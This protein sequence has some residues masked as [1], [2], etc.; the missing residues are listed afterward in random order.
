MCGLE[1]MITSSQ[2]HHLKFRNPDPSATETPDGRWCQRQR[3]IDVCV[4]Y[5]FGAVQ[6]DCVECL[7]SSLIFNSVLES[8]PLTI[9][10]LVY[11]IST[12]DF[13]WV[14][15][16]FCGNTW[17]FSPNLS[18][19]SSLSVSFQSFR[20]IRQSGAGVRCDFHKAE[21]ARELTLMSL[22]CVGFCRTLQLLEFL[23]L[24]GLCHLA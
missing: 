14:S 4:A 18:A 11:K 10:F 5:A 24:S 12:F 7:K 1:D 13:T 21:T 23:A 9:V 17:C 20:F 6:K 19:F 16:T 8:I 22:L 3:L 2:Q 15:L